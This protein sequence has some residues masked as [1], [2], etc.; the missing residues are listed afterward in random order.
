[1]THN[2]QL[3]P[4]LDDLSILDEFRI[5]MEEKPE[6]ATEVLVWARRMHSSARLAT[7]GFDDA[8]E[9]DEALGRYDI[10]VSDHG[11]AART[12]GVLE[13]RL[14]LLVNSFNDLMS[15]VGHSLGC[16]N[17]R[18][19]AHW[20]EFMKPPRPHKNQDP[21][22]MFIFG[23]GAEFAPGLDSFAEGSAPEDGDDDEQQGH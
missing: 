19:D 11:T 1:M 21:P 7:L 18:C 17:P 5:L 13:S 20:D 3:P 15:M 23:P 16:A 12:V 4:H 14:T 9:V 6:Q 2:H 10:D 8:Q 22:V